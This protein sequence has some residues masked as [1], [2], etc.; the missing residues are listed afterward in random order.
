MQNFKYK[1]IVLYSPYSLG[2]HVA[3]MR[4]F[5]KALLN[6]NCNVLLLMPEP[7]KVSDWVYAN[8]KCDKQS[9][10]YHT[11][12]PL[13]YKNHQGKFGEARNVFSIWLQLKKQLHEVEHL[14]KFKIDLVF[15][16]WVDSMMANYLPY[17]LINLIFP[18]KWS[19]LYFHPKF[20]RQNLNN[21]SAFNKI[22]ISSIDNVFRAKNCINI[23]VHDNKVIDIMQKRIGK[24]VIFFPEIADDS[25]PNNENQIIKEI[26]EKAKGRIIIGMIGL[27]ERKGLLTMIRTAKQSSKNEFFF[28]F[29]GQLNLVS[30]SENETSEIISFFNELPENCYSYL[31]YIQ[32]GTEVNSFINI[33]DIIF[34]VYN[35]FTST[36]NLNTKA[37]IFKK[38]VLTTENY[39]IGEETKEFNLGV[40]V[41]EKNVEQC[42][43]GLRKLKD[44]IDSKN[45]GAINYNGYLKKHNVEALRIAF[46]KIIN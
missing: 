31:N 18:Y 13:L 24:P 28:L 10:K 14:S 11:L 25:E 6:L 23:T 46:Q 3:F 5:S 4:L 15:F 36:S 39:I 2:H 34:I 37:A 22:S 40:T 29:A 38:L 19:G 20:I 44:I 45:Y 35:N 8:V 12:T 32:E 41:Q 17:Q 26:K 21:V 7:E 1:N 9:F 16:A 42:V 27:D 33:I 30:F 43:E